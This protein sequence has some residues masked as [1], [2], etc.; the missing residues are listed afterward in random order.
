MDSIGFP[1]DQSHITDIQV[2]NEIL[3]QSFFEKSKEDSI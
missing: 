3:D 2:G 1:K